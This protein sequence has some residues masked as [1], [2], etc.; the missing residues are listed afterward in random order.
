MVKRYLIDGLF[1]L[2]G[3]I[4]L[5]QCNRSEAP[6]PETKTTVVTATRTIP[7]KVIHDTVW[8]PAPKAPVSSRPAP[9][10]LPPAAAATINTY[11]D[12]ANFP[13]QNAKVISRTD[14]QG[15][16]LDRSIE[17][18]IRK[19]TIFKETTTTIVQQAPAR[20][21]LYATAA[22]GTRDAGPGATV[23]APKGLLYQYHY[24]I[25]DGGHQVGIG[26]LIRL[27]R[28]KKDPG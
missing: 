14:V 9:A 4:V 25:V 13:E 18:Q 17:L 28:K 12:T 27:S 5:W 22:A 21:Q 3:L 11:L 20:W 19:D 26:K 6:A 15:V 23:I 10:P 7:G 24:N 1:I 16:L 2:V 8:I